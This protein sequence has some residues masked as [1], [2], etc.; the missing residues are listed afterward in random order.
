MA[1]RSAARLRRR[2][3]RLGI[4]HGALA[5][6]AVGLVGKAGKE[7]LWRGAYWSRVAERQHYLADSLP[8]PRGEIL[9]AAGETLVES[10]ELVQLKVAPRE[11]KSR[12]ALAAALRK[13]GVPNDWVKRAIDLKRAWVEIPVELS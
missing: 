9:D 3:D 1:G 4:V 6:F 13:A 8:A 12:P 7:Q 10:R 11:V 5:L 2:L